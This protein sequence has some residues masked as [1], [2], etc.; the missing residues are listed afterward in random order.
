[1]LYYTSKG[2]TGGIRWKVVEESG[3]VIYLGRNGDVMMVP[4]MGLNGVLAGYK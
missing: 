3:G 1:M 2:L 4:E